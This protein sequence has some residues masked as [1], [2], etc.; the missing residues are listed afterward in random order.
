MIK[1]KKIVIAGGSGFIGNELISY[2]GKENQIVVL[3]RHVSNEKT[4]RNNYQFTNTHDID[5]VKWVKWDAK[6]TGDWC[7]ELENADI[8][9]NL[10]GKTVNCR[11]TNKNKKEILD[12]R[13]KA[14]AALGNAINICNTPPKLWINASSATIYRN[15]FDNPQDEMNGEMQNDFSVQ[16]CKEWEASFYGQLTENTRKIAL[17]MAITLGPG[18]VMIPYFNLLKFALGGKQGSGQQMY[19]WIHIED[20]CRIIEWLF[21][22]DEMKGTYNCVAP[23]AVTNKEF[24]RILRKV[25]GHK[26]GLPAYEWMLR[27]GAPLIGTEV[28]LVLKSRWVI[29]TRLLESGYRF[30]F[31]Q[32]EEALTDI[33]LKV[34]RRQYHLF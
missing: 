30:K 10:S 21:D 31:P 15:S 29:P 11:Y 6:N 32:L 12:S 1:N 24:M 20:T 27:L 23:V 16:V 7:T 22:H 4:N 28:E 2:F 17:R 19:S 26:F 18:G 33:I 14:T 8:L 3:T 34:P 25:T 5:K 9:I 13:V